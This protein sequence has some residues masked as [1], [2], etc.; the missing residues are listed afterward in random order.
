MYKR[1]AYHAGF[2]GKY[3]IEKLARIPVEVDIASEFRYRSPIIDDRTLT[4]VI[5]Q[6][7]ETS[8]TLAA[9]KE[10]KRLSLIHI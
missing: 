9:L 4:I 7:G 6:S 2:V 10:A 1:Q 3:Y 5:S 8:D